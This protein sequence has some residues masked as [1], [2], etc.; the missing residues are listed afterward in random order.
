MNRFE[1]GGATIA[2]T[3]TGQPH[4]EA[5]TL[6]LLHGFPLSHAMWRGQIESLR[7]VCRVIAPDLRGHGESTLGEWPTPQT[8]DRYADDVAAL[9]ESLEPRRPLTLAGFSMGG[10][11]A[12]ALLRQ[13]V[14]RFDRLALIDTKAAADTEE[15]RATRLKMAE[16][17]H[18]WG[19]ARV[20][21]LMR[22][23]LFARGTPNSIVEETCEVIA[24]TDPAA[25]AAAQRAM[26]ARPDSSDLLGQIDQSTLVVVGQ[27]DEISTSAEMRQIA[28]A[29]PEARF[30]EIAGAGHMA[31]VEQPAAVN[32]A[33]LEF[34]IA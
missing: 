33:L 1:I 18:E 22:P 15:A 14:D 26:G 4:A 28:E 30:V 34:V 10:Y 12:F 13:Y 32:Q 21:E 5:P 3:D 9:L 2:Y 23:K 17:V 8:I 29:I 24:S 31:P 25:I 11:V 7:E 27:Q 19:S 16:K 6:V 20:A